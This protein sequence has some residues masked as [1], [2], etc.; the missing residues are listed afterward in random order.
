MPSDL[1]SG[2]PFRADHIGSL[3]RPAALKEAREK[4]L[5]PQTSDRN[6]GPHGNP[7]LA[8][9]EDDAIRGVV[10]M[11]ERVG[12]RGIT[13]GEFRRRSWWL[14]MIMSWDGFAA[15]R[16]GSPEF[17]WRRPDGT[18]ANSSRLSIVG[19]IERRRSALVPAF[20]FLAAATTRMPKITLPAPIWLHMM[21][22]GDRLIRTGY[23]QDVDAFWA[24]LKTAYKAELIDLAAA[25]AKYIQFDDVGMA[26]LCDP[27][28]RATIESWGEQPDQLIAKYVRHVNDIL[29]AVPAD[30]IVTMHQ[31]RGNREGGWAAEGGYDPV[32]D[33][34]FN[35]FDFDGYFLEWDTPRAGGFEPLRH[36]PK[37]KTAVLGIMSSKSGELESADFLKRRVDEAARF[38]SI[39]QLAISPQCGF[40]SSIGGN[41]L[42]EAEQEA[43]LARIV[44]VATSIWGTV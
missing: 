16:T 42:S 24:D 36:L 20:K 3:L 11:Q 15:D 5:G 40:A 29:A 35:R 19:P 17:A 12:L 21:A 38:A 1:K 28:H 27:E 44:E 39:D 25:G 33:V 23:Y 22:G 37:G 26:F 43:K 31:C 41:P 18:R 7:D 8:A 13:D 9:V 30:V 32:A 2:P 14:E 4:F 34:L 10:A 6:L